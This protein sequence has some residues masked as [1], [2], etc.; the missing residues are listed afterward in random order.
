MPDATKEVFVASLECPT[1]ALPSGAATTLRRC[2]R[3]WCG[4][5]SESESAKMREDLL[6]YCKQDTLAMVRVIQALGGLS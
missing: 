1:K 5:R 3:G 2:S 4:E 6:E